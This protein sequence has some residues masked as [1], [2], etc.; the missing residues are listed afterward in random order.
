HG[1]ADRDRREPR[2]AGRGRS[3][4]P[5]PRAARSAP[6]SSRMKRP[7]RASQSYAGRGGRATEIRGACTAPRISVESR[8]LLSRYFRSAAG[9]TE[10][11]VVR[12]APRSCLEALGLLPAIELFQQA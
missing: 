3:L 5:A 1:G 6:F 2:S 8:E 9:A 11:F 7:C 4:G 12:R 10:K